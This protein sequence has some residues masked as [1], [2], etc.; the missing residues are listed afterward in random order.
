[1]NCES[2]LEAVSVCA[3]RQATAHVALDEVAMMRCPLHVEF[4]Q[5]RRQNLV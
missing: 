4:H 3:E 1:M 2:Y 5:Q